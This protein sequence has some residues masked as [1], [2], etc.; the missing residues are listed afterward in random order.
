MPIPT[1]GSSLSTNF[2]PI[3]GAVTAAGP[4]VTYLDTAAKDS[5]RFYQVGLVP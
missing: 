3:S 5:S 4:A 2:V 1:L